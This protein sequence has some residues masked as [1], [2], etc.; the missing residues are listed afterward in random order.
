MTWDDMIADL[1][2]RHNPYH[3]ATITVT[4]RLAIWNTLH[5]AHTHTHIASPQVKT[6]SGNNNEVATYDS[7]NIMVLMYFLW[8]LFSQL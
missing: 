8:Q 1:L 2:F 4:C 3:W 6:K 5:T 7:I